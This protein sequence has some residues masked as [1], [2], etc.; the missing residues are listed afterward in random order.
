[1]EERRFQ[2]RVYRE[3]SPYG[4]LKAPPFHSSAI[5]TLRHHGNRHGLQHSQLPSSRPPPSLVFHSAESAAVPRYRNRLLVPSA[6]LQS[7]PSRFREL[8][9][10]LMHV[11][12]VLRKWQTAAF[13]QDRN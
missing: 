1:M 13:L 11:E 9:D 8:L 6:V 4:A 5:A 10:P 7:F 2:C 3:L 12:D